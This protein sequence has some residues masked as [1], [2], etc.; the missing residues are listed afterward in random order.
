MGRQLAITDIVM[1]K[2]NR[3]N[4]GIHVIVHVLRHIE[5]AL[6]NPQKELRLLGVTDH[7]SRESD[8]AV[9]IFVELAAKDRADVGLEPAAI[10][11]NL[12]P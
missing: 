2:W 6:V 11:Q 4:L 1:L 8:P 3:A 7:A 9:L 12:Q 5:E 10:E